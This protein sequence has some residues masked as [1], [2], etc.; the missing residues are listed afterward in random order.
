MTSSLNLKAVNVAKEKSIAAAA[1][2]EFGM[3]HSSRDNINLDKCKSVLPF[4]WF[5][6]TQFFTN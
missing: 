2:M 6:L 3:K 1:A 5:M 4:L